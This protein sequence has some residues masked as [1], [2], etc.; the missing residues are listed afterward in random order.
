MPIDEAQRLLAQRISGET[1]MGAIVGRFLN[2]LGA[3]GAECAPR[4]LDRLGRVAADLITA[5]L[6]EQHDGAGGRTGDEPPAGP[7]PRALL[8][9][10]DTFIEH[11]LGDPALTP[12]SIADR[13]H[14]SVRRLHLL[15]QDRGEGVAA[16]IRRRR[17]EHCHADLARPELLD[18]PVHAI[19]ARWGFSSAAVFSRA[20]R[21]AYGTSPTAR[22]AQ[23]RADVPCRA[24]PV[25]RTGDNASWTRRHCTN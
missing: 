19:A 8:E 17:L 13:H 7:G 25:I 24:R 15:F 22:R 23:A 10:I 2:T 12:Q 16:T 9:R 5:C 1:G 3:H 4:D 20:Y 18:R 14:I 11:N 6:A 21:Q